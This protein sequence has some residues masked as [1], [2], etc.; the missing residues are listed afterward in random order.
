MSTETLFENWAEMERRQL[1][2]FF[3]LYLNPYVAQTCYC[4][5]Q[6]VQQVFHTTGQGEA[7]YPSFLANSFEEAVSGAMKLARFGANGQ[8]DSAAGLIVDP[9]GRLSNLAAV[10]LADGSELEFIPEIDV[11]GPGRAIPEKRYGF[12]LVFADNEL[13]EAVQAVIREQSPIVIACVSAEVLRSPDSLAGQLRRMPDVVVFDGS[14]VRGQVPFAA[15]AARKSLYDLWTRRGYTTFHSTTFQP[16]TLTSLHFLKCLEADAAEF[17]ARHEAAL[18]AIAGDTRSCKQV[19][20]RLYNPSLCKTITTLGMDTLDASATGHYVRVGGRRIFDGISGIAC[21]IR[22]HNPPGYREAMRRLEPLQNYHA[23]AEKRLQRLS[24]LEHMLPAVSGASAVENALRLALVAQH[25]RRHVLALR[26]GFGGKT[27]F[28]LTGTANPHYKTRLEPLYAD[29][30]YIDPFAP[31][32]VAQL[33][34]ALDEQPVA[35]VQM[36]LVQGVGGVRAVPEEVVRFLDAEKRKRGYLLFVDEVQTGMYRTGPFLRST[37]LGITPDLVTIGKGVSDMMF[38]FS[39]T[40]YSAALR[41]RL[42][43]VKP[44]FLDSLRQKHDLEFGYKTLL[45]ALDA[46]EQTGIAEQVAWS[47]TRFLELLREGLAGCKTVRDVRGFGLLIAIEL[48]VTRGPRRWLKKQAHSVY[49]LDMLRDPMFPV[50]VGFCQ[51]EPH[52]LKLTPPLTTTEAEIARVCETLVKT[53]RRPFHR[54]LP[55]CLG[56]FAQSYIRHRTTREVPV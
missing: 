41:K 29:V 44:G 48:D 51:Y 45:N 43:A 23:E 34:A 32:A 22:G 52:V 53:L 13:P 14:F 46:A 33:D 37:G 18:R 56:V 4:L 55:G 47:G 40:L 3:R 42:E 6:L 1:P 54:L 30:R 36:E 25:P 9:E 50:L 31:N 19:L 21:S 12:V 17:H 27:L 2:N 7:E 5:N 20:T 24:D 35:V 10:T 38:P 26:G 16:N 39:A 28:A 11:I 49:L 15:F 8:G